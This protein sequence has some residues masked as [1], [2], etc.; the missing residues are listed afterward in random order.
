MTKE[1]VLILEHW[2]EILNFDY[3]SR[4]LIVSVRPTGLQS[5]LG[6]DGGFDLRF[7]GT[8][9]IA[10]SRWALRM[11]SEL[12]L[13]TQARPR[14]RQTLWNT[15]TRSNQIGVGGQPPP[16]R[17]SHIATGQRPKARP[18]N[19]NE[20]KHFSKHPQIILNLNRL[21]TTHCPQNWSM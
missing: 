13:T 8:M 14:L 16:R 15:E 11:T 6:A 9:S 2:T 1:L 3:W 18:W 17:E 19:Q 7:P 12:H 21:Y 4:D 10:H 5:K 20:H